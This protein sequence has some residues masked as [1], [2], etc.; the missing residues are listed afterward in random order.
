M[1]SVSFLHCSGFK[2][3]LY[4]QIPIYLTP[5]YLRV[6]MIL[7]SQAQGSY[8]M[9]VLNAPLLMNMPGDLL[10]VASALRL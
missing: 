6:Q 2:E 10:Y 1:I 4:A 5:V 9:I 3:I 7:L 8:L